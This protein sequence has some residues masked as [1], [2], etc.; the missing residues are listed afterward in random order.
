MKD[1]VPI[2]NKAILMATE[3]T[4]GPVF[5]ECPIDLL[6]EESLVKEWYLAGNKKDASLSDKAIYWYLNRHVQ[7][8]FDGVKSI[9]IRADI[10]P[11]QKATHNSSHIKS[12]KK[13][14]QK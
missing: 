8:V 6:Y 7:A 4:P 10:V 14:I 11:A 13:S 3:G 2:I 1:F 12:I 9:D 5:V